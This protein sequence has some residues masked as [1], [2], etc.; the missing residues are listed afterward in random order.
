MLAVLIVNWETCGVGGGGVV[1]SLGSDG[2]FVGLVVDGVDGERPGTSVVVWLV[3]LVSFV[4][5]VALFF[6]VSGMRLVKVWSLAVGRDGG[7]YHW[8]LL[9]CCCILCVWSSTIENGIVARQGGQVVVAIVSFLL[10]EVC[11]DTPPPR[12]LWHIFF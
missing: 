9:L 11:T 10:P 8:V 6:F 7:I 3:P 1:L 4:L 5:V 2:C 12:Q